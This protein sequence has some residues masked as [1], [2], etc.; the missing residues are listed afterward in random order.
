[1]SIWRW[2]GL[3]ILSLLSFCQYFFI[4]LK[5]HEYGPN[6][7]SKE[8]LAA[9]SGRVA[10]RSSK[11]GWCE[12]EGNY[13]HMYAVT[14]PGHRNK[15]LQ[16]NSWAKIKQEPVQ[17]QN[18]SLNSQSRDAADSGALADALPN[19]HANIKHTHESSGGYIRQGSI[20]EHLLGG[21][22]RDKTSKCQLIME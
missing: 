18:K 9:V 13:K 3:F 10:T 22:I 14:L 6:R 4:F 21:F 17:A 12:L 11:N 19:I 5:P 2:K 16:Q 20:N 7:L 1:M 15:H 8:I